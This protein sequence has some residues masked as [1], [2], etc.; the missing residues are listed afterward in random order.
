M[1]ADPTRSDPL[2]RLDLEIGFYRLI[3]A[4]RA[5]AQLLGSASQVDASPD[6]L[7][8]LFDL[9]AEKGQT[10]ARQSGFDIA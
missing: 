4:A 5:A 8:A 1:C 2:D 9:I 7:G 10:L 3:G 6:D